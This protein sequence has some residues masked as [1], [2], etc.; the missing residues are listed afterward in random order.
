MKIRDFFK[1]EEEIFQFCE[2]FRRIEELKNELQRK[3][4]EELFQLLTPFFIFAIKE[5]GKY[6]EEDYYAPERWALETTNLCNICRGKYRINGGKIKYLPNCGE[7]YVTRI[8]K[9][10]AIEIIEDLFPLLLKK[11]SK[12]KELKEISLI[13]SKIKEI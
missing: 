4:E 10:N 6:I 5:L 13:L 11:L 1:K 3:R 12:N 9:E 7:R 2:D 8:S